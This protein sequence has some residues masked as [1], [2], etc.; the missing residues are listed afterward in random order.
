MMSMKK[1]Y[2]KPVAEII[3]VDSSDIIATSVPID[4]DPQ[5]GLYG[6]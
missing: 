4:P 2:A 5:D 6:D 1:K 3:I